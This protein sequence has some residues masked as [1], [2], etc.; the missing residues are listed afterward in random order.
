MTKFELIEKTYKDEIYQ[1]VYTWNDMPIKIYVK[2]HFHTLKRYW[3]TY[4]YVSGYVFGVP[5][6]KMDEFSYGRKE[7]REIANKF[8][9][10]IAKDPKALIDSIDDFHK[11][12]FLEKRRV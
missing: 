4:V 1:L 12:S 3:S 6:E 2:M 10:K 9:K 8:M 7:A 11:K 5:I